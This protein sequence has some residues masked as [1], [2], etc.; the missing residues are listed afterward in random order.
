M[1]ELQRVLLVEDDERDIE[2][3]LTALSGHNLAN[4]VDVTHDGVEA[5]EYLRCAGEY[6]ERTSDPPAVVVMDLK[7][8]RMGGIELLTAMRSDETMCRIPAVVLT[9]SREEV[10]LVKAYELGVNGYVVKPV[11]FQAFMDAVRS[12]GIYWAMVNEPPIQATRS[13]ADTG[14]SS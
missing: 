9:S 7:M 4:S 6:A 5:L 14:A 1:S 12:V 11:E 2:L 10:D 13:A 8:P 3:T